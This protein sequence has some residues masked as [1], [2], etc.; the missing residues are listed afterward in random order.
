MG[1]F[2]LRFLPTPVW[3]EVQGQG[4]LLLDWMS[5]E[6]KEW[7]D[8]NLPVLTDREHTFIGGSSMGGLMALYAGGRYSSVY[9]R[10]ACLSPYLGLVMEPLCEDLDEAW[11]EE[12]TQFYIS[13]GGMETGTQEEL[14]QITADNLTIQRI[15]EDKAS[16]YL[17]CYPEGTHC[18]A[19]WEEETPVWMEEIRDPAAVLGG[20]RMINFVLIS[21]HFPSNYWL[22]ARALKNSR[23][24]RAGDC[25]HDR[26]NPCRK[27][28][29]QCWTTWSASTR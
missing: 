20:N 13:W 5:G 25:R 17:H 28:C 24:A 8:E 18:E 1:V 6:L 15:L 29:G 12:D 4:E 27:H 14:A 9:S 3:G 11:I 19:C 21:P 16:V 22:F 7:V 26:W 10:A 2:T 23:R